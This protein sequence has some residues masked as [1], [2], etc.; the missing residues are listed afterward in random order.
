MERIN[1][2]IFVVLMGLLSACGS[3]VNIDFE[4]PSPD[5]S[6]IATFYTESGG[7]AAGWIAGRVNLRR[8]DEPFSPKKF[9]FQMSHGYQARIDW[10][11]A[12]TLSIGYPFG[13]DVSRE[14]SDFDPRLS[15]EL[16]P[17]PSEDESFI[18]QSAAGC[19]RTDH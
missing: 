5:G 9:V 15:I 11:K 10:S 18:D 19:V 16:K 6:L 13:A 8:K 14:A 2:A 3:Q 17:Y 7:G 4:C 1:G 12:N